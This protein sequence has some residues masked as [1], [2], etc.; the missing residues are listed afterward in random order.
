VLD[1]GLGIIG[2]IPERILLLPG[3]IVVVLV[4][5]F[6]A[7]EASAFVGF[8]FPGEITVILG[9]V[10]ASQG[11]VPLWAVIAAAVSGAIIGDSVGYLIGRRWGT[12]LLYGTVGQLPVI[13]GQLDKHLG[14]AEAFVRRRKGRAVFFG[15][16]TAALRVLVP[17]LAGMSKVHYPSFLAYN[18]AGGV[19]WGGGFVILGYVAGASYARVEQVASRVGLGLLALAVLSIVLSRVLRRLGQ[20]STSLSSFGERLAAAPPLTWARQRF[21]NQVAW[22]GRRLDVT[23][24][25]GFWLTFTITGGALAA[26]AFA[27][28][29]Q[30]V[31]GHDEMALFDPR[32]EQWVVAVRT[33]WLTGVMKS[34]TWLGSNA[35][36]VPALVL[37][38]AVLVLRGRDWRS[39]IL[40]GSAVAGAVGLY[41]I[42]KVA[43]ER[44]RPPSTV[45]IGDFSGAAY[46]S[47]HATQAVAFYGVL[48]LVLSAKRSPGVRVLVW[49]GAA[50]I[51]LLVGASRLYLGAHWLTD[52][53]AGYALGAAW[54]ALVAAISL[55]AEGRGR[56]GA[57]LPMTS[58]SGRS[59][60]GGVPK[61]DRNRVGA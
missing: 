48:A 59:E 43:V 16:F 34:V 19:L 61:R 60:T 12:D 57:T 4:F 53:L 31:V 36:I 44:P 41:N 47:G 35:V 24:P 28:L 8:V 7:L 55:L 27:G 37:V 54:A 46:P 13:R 2:S 20:R 14:S 26:W 25:K 22:V 6:P 5:A 3:W 15:R 29:T 33:P 56:R 45:W 30:D 50:V 32:A 1:F 52:V 49:T 42:V 18:V 17:G 10:A 23:T 11:L 39:A 40:L 51:T 21:P 38:A 9:G 58:P